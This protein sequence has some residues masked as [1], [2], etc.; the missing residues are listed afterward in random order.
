MGEKN[1]QIFLLYKYFFQTIGTLTFYWDSDV[2]SFAKDKN[3]YSSKT[4]K[5]NR[6]T[7]RSTAALIPVFITGCPVTTK[8]GDY[9]TFNTPRFVEY[10]SEQL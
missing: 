3:L 7:S 8:W 2:L 1:V 9:I 4:N 6:K 5:Y 10:I